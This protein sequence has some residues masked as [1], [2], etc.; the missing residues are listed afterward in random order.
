MARTPS[1]MRMRQ[2]KPD[3]W[4]NEGLADLDETSGL[5]VRLGYLGLCGCADEYGRFEWRPRKAGAE[6]FP[7]FPKDMTTIMDLLLKAG[8]LHRYEVDGQAFGHFPHWDRHYVRRNDTEAIWPVP[9]CCGSLEAIPGL[10]LPAKGGSGR[11]QEGSDIGSGSGSDITIC[12][13]EY[14]ESAPVSVQDE[15]PVDSPVVSPAHPTQDGPG[16]ELASTL[17]HLLDEPKEFARN[18]WPTLLIPLLAEH[19]A[20]EITSVM[21]FAVKDNTF[22]AEYL[23][24]AKEPMASFVKTYDNLLKRWKALQKG[25]AAAANRQSKLKP[26]TAPSGHKNDSGMEF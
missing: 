8:Y 14:Q 20:D 4:K 11:L 2:L 7:Y 10:Q 5:P 23:A 12:L 16:I 1:M 6:V 26:T 17:W 21:K 15:V 19:P 22:S 25:A 3:F 24:L 9:T 13:N 18:N